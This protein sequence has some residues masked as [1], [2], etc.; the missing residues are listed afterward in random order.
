MNWSRLVS[1]F[2]FLE[3][4]GAVFSRELFAPGLSFRVKPTR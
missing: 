3:L 2:S 4:L 1:K